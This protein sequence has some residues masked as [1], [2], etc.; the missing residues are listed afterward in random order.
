MLTIFPYSS[1]ELYVNQ[2]IDSSIS[3][4]YAKS[5]PAKE[6]LSL[7]IKRQ[8]ATAETLIKNAKNPNL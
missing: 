4:E 3:N 1:A 2:M 6:G 8:Y 5:N 7:L